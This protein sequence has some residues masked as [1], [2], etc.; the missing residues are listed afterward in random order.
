MIGT[1]IQNITST[2]CF[3]GELQ[4]IEFLVLS[5]YVLLYFFVVY[6]LV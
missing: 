1:F 5:V 6:L 2:Q 3:I 4:I